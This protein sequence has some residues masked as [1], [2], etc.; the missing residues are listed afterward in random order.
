[1]PRPTNAAAPRCARTGAYARC[2]AR[3][4]GHAYVASLRN[5]TPLYEITDHI[6]VLRGST[7]RKVMGL[8]NIVMI[9]MSNWLLAVIS[10]RKLVVLNPLFRS[11]RLQQN[12]SMQD[13]VLCMLDNTSHTLRMLL[14]AALCT[15]VR[16]SAR[17]GVARR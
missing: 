9:V 2:V 7:A 10:G 13:A 17:Y 16:P 11:V 3:R 12:A 14:C 6:L 8:G 1:M 5:A 4:L 15:G